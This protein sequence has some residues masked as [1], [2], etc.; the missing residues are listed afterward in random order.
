MKIVLLITLDKLLIVIGKNLFSTWRFI[1]ITTG[2]IINSIKA[3]NIYINKCI[4]FSCNFSLS[5][6]N[7]KLKKITTLKIEV[8]AKNI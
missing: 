2:S 7:T 3:Q 1:Y 4:K 8:N 6:N 5:V